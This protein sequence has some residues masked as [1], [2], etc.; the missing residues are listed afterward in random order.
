MNC[1]SSFCWSMRP[2]N[3]MD[4]KTKR[5]LTVVSHQKRI[6][7]KWEGNCPGMQFFLKI[8]FW[9]N[10]KKIQFFNS[11]QQVVLILQTEIIFLQDPEIQVENQNLNYKHRN[12]SHF[13]MSSSK[14]V[15]FW[16]KC[17]TTRQI[18]FRVFWN[19]SNFEKIFF[20]LSRFWYK[21]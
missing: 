9:L 18:L 21:I 17:F 6:V 5:I 14:L 15:I 11:I 12:M 1:S 2:I 8:L 19:N 3:K 13:E 7:A 10:S 16:H 4:R 20:S